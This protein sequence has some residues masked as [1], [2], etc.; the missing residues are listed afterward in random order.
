MLSSAPVAVG[1]LGGA[2]TYSAIAIAV[3]AG[4]VGVLTSLRNYKEISRSENK[5]VLQKR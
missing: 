5:L 4:G 1:I 2:A 3:A